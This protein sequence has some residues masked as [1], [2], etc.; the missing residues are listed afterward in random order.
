M[1]YTAAFNRLM[2]YAQPDLEPCVSLADLD[3]LLAEHAI[4]VDSDGYNPS[5]DGYTDTYS[6]V[7][8]YRAAAEAWAL[9][10]GRA[11]DRFDFT[12]DGQQFRRSQALDHFQAMA[13]RYRRKASATASTGGT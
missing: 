2:M 12:T 11:A 8:V 4:A 13:D 7:G 9:R 6:T 1:N 3:A 10:M 5:D